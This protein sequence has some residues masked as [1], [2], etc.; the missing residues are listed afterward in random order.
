MANL[1]NVTTLDQ[2][3]TWTNTTSGE[4][5]FISFLV[6][7]FAITF[8]YGMQRGKTTALIYSGFVCTIVS[9]LLTQAGYLSW[10]WAL[11]SFIVLVIGVIFKSFR[12][13]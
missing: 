1:T 5:F 9:F 3:I 4:F 7:L 10:V 12:E 8:I 6:G 11:I 2:L 13:E